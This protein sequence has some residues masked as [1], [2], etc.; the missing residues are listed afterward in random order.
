MNL[1]DSVNTGF[2][3][4]GFC[5]LLC[6][7]GF[8]QVRL[9]ASQKI[10]SAFCGQISRKPC[11]EPPKHLKRSPVRALE[12]TSVLASHSLSLPPQSATGTLGPQQVH[13]STSGESKHAAAMSL[14]ELSTFLKESPTFDDGSW[15]WWSGCLHH[16]D[17]SW[18]SDGRGSCARSR[19]SPGSVGWISRP[20]PS[21][22]SSCYTS[23]HIS[24]L[25]TLA[26][27]HRLVTASSVTHTTTPF[28][29]PLSAP[30]SISL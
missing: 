14:E 19:R 25:S 17:G 12:A 3:V 2:C 5:V 22:P 29:S 20:E 10:D 18:A 15:W 23:S 11:C 27:L 26:A 24:R 16:R 30:I 1:E 9:D 28:G 7:F 13:R 8:L 21:L 4:I 6:Y